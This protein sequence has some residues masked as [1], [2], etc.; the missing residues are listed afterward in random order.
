MIV[1]VE[2]LNESDVHM[3]VG[4]E[5][6]ETCADVRIQEQLTSFIESLSHLLFNF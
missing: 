3:F 5:R 1:E 2:Q 6:E 4:S